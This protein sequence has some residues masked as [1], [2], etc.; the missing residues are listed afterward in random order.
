MKEEIKKI[1]K[2]NGYVYTCKNIIGNEVYEKG[3]KIVFIGFNT[4]KK[5]K[6]ETFEE[7]T[8]RMYK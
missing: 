4:F 7:M 8:K 5:E 3:N 6:S 1:L 2:K